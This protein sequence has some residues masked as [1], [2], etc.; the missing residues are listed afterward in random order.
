MRTIVIG[1]IH[2][3]YNTF[4]ALLKKVDY[5]KS[6]DK[7]VLLGD[8]ID[9]GKHNYEVV[10]Y[11]IKLQ[12]EVGND[13]CVC[14]M[15]NHEHMA[16]ND[17]DLWKYNGGNKTIS[18]YF[19]NNKSPDYHFWWFKQLP[20]YHETENFIFVHA[21]LPNN[22]IEENTLHDVLWDRDW[23]R[24][25]EERN[26]KQIIFGHT[27]STEQGYLATDGS[28]CIDTG[29]VYGYQLCACVIA[30]ENNKTMR[31]YYEDKSELD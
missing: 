25:K 4:L 28:M 21:G 13:S 16:F 8:Y 31:L 17:R 1:D 10:D 15:G 24:T 30:N 9:R 19:K 6:V 22:K 12:K 14:L 26:E 5:D 11:L 18:S 20:L 23:I 7:L 29:C 27:P 3:C 2:G